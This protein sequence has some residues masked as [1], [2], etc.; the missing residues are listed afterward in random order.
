MAQTCRRL[1]DIAVPIL[2][3]HILHDSPPALLANQLPDFGIL[4][5]LRALSSKPALGEF[6][7]SMELGDVRF[8]PH[9][10]L[11]GADSGV[12]QAFS[13]WLHQKFGID[14][15]GFV[16]PDPAVVLCCL[17]PNLT[18][19]ILTG[20]RYGWLQSTDFL[21]R[22]DD[23]R[24]IIGAIFVF[25]YLTDLTIQ[26]D[27]LTMLN[28]NFYNGLLH[29][30]PNLESLTIEKPSGG[31]LLSANLRNL[32]TLK[33]MDAYI[34][35]RGLAKLTKT[36]ST[37]RHFEFSNLQSSRPVA[38]VSPA[39]ILACLAPSADTLQTLHIDN[40]LPLNRIPDG[41][42]FHLVEHLAGFPALRH[43]A[44]NSRSIL[45]ERNP[46]HALVDLLA[47]CL[48]LERVFIFNMGSFSRLELKHLVDKVAMFEWPRLKIIQLSAY[49]DRPTLFD[50]DMEGWTQFKSALYKTKKD[51]NRMVRM[52]GVVLLYRSGNEWL[53]SSTDKPA[54]LID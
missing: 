3:G 42:P 20:S 28:L 38:L 25:R 37:L 51:I 24:R 10:Q 21:L 29:A 43:L 6:V 16:G 19:L 17:T 39:G 4:S 9:V 54:G 48:E 15:E 53:N 5:L 12:V 45:R 13:E 36:C 31:S 18:K 34:G 26:A 30:A 27:D 49:S 33:L 35:E 11:E 32:T 46:K 23:N 1:C 47:G 52:T 41:R 22:R 14:I 44:I 8:P 50:T 40:Y 7:R 2:Y